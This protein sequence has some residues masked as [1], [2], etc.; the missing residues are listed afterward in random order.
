MRARS[1]PEWLPLLA[2][3]SR[4]EVDDGLPAEGGAESS[5][6]PG[7]AFPDFVSDN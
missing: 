6:F 4:Q 5:S 2:Y 1:E 3:V 7:F